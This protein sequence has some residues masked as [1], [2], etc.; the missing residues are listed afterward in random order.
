MRLSVGDK[1][2]R[3]EILAPIGAGGMGEV[4]R[5]RDGRLG[6][7]VALKVLPAVFA[8]DGPRRA[9]FEHEARSA[10][11]LNHPNIVSVFDVGRQDEILFII[12]EFVDGESLRAVVGRG[13]V[14]SKAAVAIGAQIAEGLSAAHEVGVVHRD[15]KPE[16][17]MLTRAGRVKILDFGLAKRM[18]AKGQLQQNAEMS[19]LTEPGTVLGT[20]GYMSPEQARGQPV[21]QRSDIFSFGTILYELISGHRPFRGEIPALVIH[22]IL[23]SDPPELPASVG[24]ALSSLILRCLE[25]EPSRRFQSAADLAFALQTLSTVSG[26]ANAPAERP[27]TRL[28]APWWGTAALLAALAVGA[29]WWLSHGTPSPR[30]QSGPVA[31]PSSQPPSPQPA[32]SIE[33]K[34]V[35]SSTAKQVKESPAPHSAASTQRSPV[36]QPVQEVPTDQAPANAIPVPVTPAAQRAVPNPVLAAPVAGTVISTPSVTFAWNAVASAQDYWLDVGTAPASGNISAGFTG[37]ANFRTVDLS[38][39]LTGQ[40]IYLQIYSMVA[41]VSLI[42]GTGNQFQF[43]TSASIFQS[44]PNG[45]LSETTPRAVGTKKENPKDELTYLWIP[46]GTFMM[47][48]SPSDG[49]CYDVE[50]PAHQVTLTKGFWLGQTEVTQAAYQRVTGQNPSSW[51]GPALPVESITWNEADGYCRAIGGRLPTE[52]EWEYAARAGSTAGRYGNFDGVAWYNGNSPNG[53]HKVAQKQANGWGLYDMLGNVWEWTADWYADY[54]PNAA[55]DPTGP[56]SGQF[57]T[58]RGGSWNG[59]PGL[60]RVSARFRFALGVTG[61][62]IG[63]RCV[64]E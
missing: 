22:A 31:A 38:H 14:A 12:T 7:D 27:R 60:V 30:R 56:A 54:L 64:G 19:T 17:I 50:K 8:Q 11:A 63:V 55:V 53:T 3:Y 43:P 1:L 2:G 39:Y 18:E 48:C 29:T 41:G 16:N 20:V 40:T 35:S 28:A 5:A 42:P 58:E 45:R 23:K 4:F 32:S 62:G 15:L 33:E 13:P 49:E 10:S 37:G 61:A 36:A 59:N 9:R 51:R 24:P 6:R 47:G 44:N 26:S 25:K 34:A 46:P 21:D 52:A 57:R